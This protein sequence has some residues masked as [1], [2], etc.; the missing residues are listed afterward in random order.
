MWVEGMVGGAFRG[1]PGRWGR[2]SRSTRALDAG[3]LGWPPVR[4]GRQDA[5]EWALR[6]IYQSVP[7]N[8]RCRADMIAFSSVWRDSGSTPPPRPQGSSWSHCWGPRPGSQE[9]QLHGHKSPREVAKG[10]TQFG[11]NSVHSR[12]SLLRPP[13]VFYGLKIDIVFF[14][15][16]CLG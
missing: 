14:W 10:F 3:Q 6:K 11:A 9:V 4:F 13:F 16:A 12:T 2:E 8:P 5:G 1:N 7:P 15:I